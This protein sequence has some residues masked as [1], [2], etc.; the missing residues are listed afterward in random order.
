MRAHALPPDIDRR[1]DAAVALIGAVPGYSAVAVELSAWKA[2]GQVRWDPG[3]PD[4]AVVHFLGHMTMGPEPFDGHLA[5][6][7]E[8]LVHEHHHRFRQHHWQKTVSYWTGIATGS[9]PMARYERP[10]TLASLRFLEDA[11]RHGAVDRTTAVAEQ[12]AIRKSWALH[13]RIPL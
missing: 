11:A 5:G 13:Y 8:T 7:A 3:L 10:A 12:N 1:F 6:L 4:R 9:P 2:K